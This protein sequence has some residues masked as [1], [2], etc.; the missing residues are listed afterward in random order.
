M[1]G[2]CLGEKKKRLCLG[3]F[4]SITFLIRIKVPGSLTL[5]AMDILPSSGFSWLQNVLGKPSSL[6]MNAWI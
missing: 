2:W 5:L 1:W 3:I 4:R 6:P